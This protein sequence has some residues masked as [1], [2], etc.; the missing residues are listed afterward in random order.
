MEGGIRRRQGR[1][2]QA[3]LTARPRRPPQRAPSAGQT[4]ALPKAAARRHGHVAQ[5]C[6]QASMH[7]HA[8]AGAALTVCSASAA[9]R[10]RTSGLL[11]MAFT[12]WVGLAAAGGGGSGGRVGG[13]VQ[14]GRH[15]RRAAR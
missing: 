4:R 3:R 12:T 1:G 15:S 10:W 11:I 2:G 6:M 8:R 5:V 14:G 9:M 13:G 7:A